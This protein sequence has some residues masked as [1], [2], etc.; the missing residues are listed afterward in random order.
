MLQGGPRLPVVHRNTRCLPN[1]FSCHSHP[2]DT[3][4]RVLLVHL[5]CMYFDAMGQGIRRF[6]GPT[7]LFIFGAICGLL[8]SYENTLNQRLPIDNV[9]ADSFCRIRPYRRARR[10]P[11]AREA[12]WL[13]RFILVLRDQEARQASL[14]SEFVVCIVQECQGLWR[15]G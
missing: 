9:S 8:V 12:S 1:L 5:V 13:G 15:H 7:L 6:R 10:P 14:W 4:H 3:I 2:E 11:S